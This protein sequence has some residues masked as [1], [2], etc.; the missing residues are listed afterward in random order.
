MFE[1]IQKSSGMIEDSSIKDQKKI[2]TNDFFNQVPVSGI[3]E[4]NISKGPN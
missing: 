2:T 3:R 4:S 1:S